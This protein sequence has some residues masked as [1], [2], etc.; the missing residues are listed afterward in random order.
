M[1][2]L[3]ADQKQQKERDAYV[4]VS[5]CTLRSKWL[6]K[7]ECGTKD[8]LCAATAVNHW[9]RRIWTMRQTVRFTAA[10]AT[11]AISDQKGLDLDWALELSPWHNNTS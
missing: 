4:A 6:A 8:V 10:H 7:I 3:S 11:D 1:A 5:Q 2:E 9:T